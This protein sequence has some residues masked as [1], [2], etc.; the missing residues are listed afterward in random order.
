MKK[1]IIAAMAA[2][3]GYQLERATSIR[4]VETI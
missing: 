3:A 4:T 2:A 1:K